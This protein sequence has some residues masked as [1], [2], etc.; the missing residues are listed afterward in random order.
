MNGIKLIVSI[1]TLLVWSFQASSQLGSVEFE[2][3]NKVDF[4]DHQFD[5]RKPSFMKVGNNAFTRYNPISLTL[6]SLLFIYQKAIS[7]QLQSRCP[8]E[9]SCSAFSKGCI[10]EYGLVKGVALTADRL[11]RC[12]QFTVIHI[13][14]SQI[15]HKRANIKNDVLKYAGK[16][17]RH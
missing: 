13:L 17:H 14:P 6:G 2:R 12:T 15:D 4:T 16:H 8:Y 1:T 10:Q 5:P 9:I 7:P 3:I 11:T